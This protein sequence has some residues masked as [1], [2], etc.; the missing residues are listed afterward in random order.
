M[1]ELNYYVV[2]RQEVG[3]VLLLLVAFRKEDLHKIEVEVFY[4]RRF[5][6]L[7]GILRVRLRWQGL[8]QVVELWR[9]VLPEDGILALILILIVTLGLGFILVKVLHLP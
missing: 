2:L 7:I 4:P 9:L 5:L 1:E 3:T 8:Y 6:V